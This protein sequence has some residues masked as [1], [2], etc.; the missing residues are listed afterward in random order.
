MRTEPQQLNVA[1]TVAPGD[2]L[3]V[4]RFRDKTIFVGGT[5]TATLRIQGS[6]DGSTWADLTADI[7]T[8]SI[9]QL[10]QTVEQIRVNTTAF[11]SG[12]PAVWFDGFDARSF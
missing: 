7:T 11:T 10:P 1:V 6:L 2:P 9:L 12:T 4:D 8:P 3:R 5:F